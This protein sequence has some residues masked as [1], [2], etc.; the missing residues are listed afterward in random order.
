MAADR[1]DR[2]FIPANHLGNARRHDPDSKLTR[3]SAFD[4]AD[5]RVARFIL[6]LVPERLLGRDRGSGDASRRSK[7]NLRGRRS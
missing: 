4:D 6:D 3:A 1:H 7:I 2:A 5:V